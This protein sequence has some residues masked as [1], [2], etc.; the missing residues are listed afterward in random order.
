MMCV[1]Y[2]Y[3]DLA[4]PKRSKAALLEVLCLC[5][6]PSLSGNGPGA[7]PWN[8]VCLFCK[9]RTP[10]LGRGTQPSPRDLSLLSPRRYSAAV[11]AET[12]GTS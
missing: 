2:S 11:Q 4:T 9:A 10:E 8:V 12:S 5:D 7:G 3:I 6:W 1:Q